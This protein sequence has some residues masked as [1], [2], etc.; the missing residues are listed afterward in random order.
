MIFLFKIDDRFA[1]SLHYFS[2]TVYPDNCVLIH[3]LWLQIFLHRRLRPFVTIP[4]IYLTL[5]PVHFTP[6]THLNDDLLSLYEIYLVESYREIGSIN[7]PLRCIIIY[8]CQRYHAIIAILIAFYGLHVNDVTRLPGANKSQ[9]T[10]RD[11]VKFS[12]CP[13]PTRI[14]PYVSRTSDRSVWFTVAHRSAVNLVP[15]PSFTFP[16]RASAKLIFQ[17]FSWL[18]RSRS[19]WRGE[20]KDWID[21]GAR[22]FLGGEIRISN[23]TSRKRRGKVYANLRFGPKRKRSRVT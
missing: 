23:P 5:T 15:I 16:P 20:G 4:I 11:V 21:T 13:W 22:E 8:H 14:L 9:T 18:T 17:N 7:K 12:S 2:P 10:R 6:S 19:G 1:F 3:A